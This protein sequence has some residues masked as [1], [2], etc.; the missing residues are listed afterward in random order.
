MENITENEYSGQSLE[1]AA[2]DLTVTESPD[3]DVA[4][5]RARYEA[6]VKAMAPRER[7]A[8]ADEVTKRLRGCVLDVADA[9]YTFEERKRLL[10]ETMQEAAFGKAWQISGYKSWDEYWQAEFTDA[11]L[12]DSVKERNELIAHL[13]ANS[14]SQRQI[15]PIVGLTQQSVQKILRKQDSDQGG[16]LTTKLSV[17]HHEGNGEATG[18]LTTELSVGHSE[19]GVTSGPVDQKPVASLAM[20]GSRGVVR[21]INDRSQSLPRSADEI[22]CDWLWIRGLKALEGKSSRQIAEERGIPR[23]TID[24]T[25]A[26]AVKDPKTRAK[27][28]LKVM[29]L[30]REGLSVAGIAEN[31]G[32]QVLAVRFV[33]ER[34]QGT[35]HRDDPDDWPGSPLAQD[36][37][38]QASL[39]EW[40]G[41]GDGHDSPLRLLDGRATSVSEIAALMGVK[42]PRVTQILE[43]WAME[44]GLPDR[45]KRT[46]QEQPEVEIVETEPQKTL[47][48]SAGISDE[49]PEVIDASMRAERHG[50]DMYEGYWRKP[51]RWTKRGEPVDSSPCQ[52]MQRVDAEITLF[53]PPKTGG[54]YS[55]LTYCMN[56]FLPRVF[57][58]YNMIAYCYQGIG[59]DNIR[60]FFDNGLMG[61]RMLPRALDSLSKSLDITPDHRRALYETV[62]DMQGELKRMETRL[63]GACADDVRAMP[64][65]HRGL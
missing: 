62:R 8:W 44:I 18:Q 41:S 45:R 51:S 5:A 4:A 20:A 63:A 9:H 53:E 21:G 23:K 24:Y 39:E 22:V 14:F 55:P 61:F 25:I 48:E 52:W 37:V 26:M 35:A 40:W 28:W 31:L 3:A 58:W 33:L 56:D 2:N 43:A 57:G 27:W 11:K 19:S 60:P 64:A 15:A 42:Q 29:D 65:G 13:K 32:L 50:D 49:R 34:M 12:F 30:S 46:A 36:L 38:D 54:Y 17:A 59:Q 16:Q 6:K 47:R 7:L 1:P 10:L